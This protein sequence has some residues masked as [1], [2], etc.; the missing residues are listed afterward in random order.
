[1]RSHAET[2]A[3]SGDLPCRMNSTT[4]TLLQAKRFASPRPVEPAAPTSLSTYKPAPRMGESPT[5][6]GILKDRPLVVVQLEMTIGFPAAAGAA[7][8]FKPAKF[9]AST[10]LTPENR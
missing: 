2:Q 4:I 8:N 10:A 3:C 5:R 6:P 9:S 1:M 7:F